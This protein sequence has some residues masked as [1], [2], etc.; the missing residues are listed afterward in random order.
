MATIAS[1]MLKKLAELRFF[2]KLVPV[3]FYLRI[4]TRSEFGPH[5]VWPW[6]RM[7]SNSRVPLFKV[8][9]GSVFKLKLRR[10]VVG[11]GGG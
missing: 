11:G 2:D 6:P 5:A 3:F 9:V 8:T 4:T 7:V 1:T 10:G